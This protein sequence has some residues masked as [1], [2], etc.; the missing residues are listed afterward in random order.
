MAESEGKTILV[1][2]DED[3]VVQF[4]EMVLQDE[5]YQVVAAADG[6]EAM[7]KIKEQK[8]DLITLD[9]IMPSKTGIGFYNDLRH[10][11]E[12]KD[13]PII[14]ITG[15]DRDSSGMISFR[16]FLESRAVSKPQAYLVKPINS[17]ELV[18]TVKNVLSG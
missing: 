17:D 12:Y 10:S 18:E 11:D 8:P 16:K 7:E 1:I 15:V 9:L 14:V 3:D 13:I 4:L 6:N 2:E 5:G